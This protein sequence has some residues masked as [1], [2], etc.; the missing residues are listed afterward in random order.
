MIANRVTRRLFLGALALI[1][2]VPAIAQTVTRGPYLQKS[3]TDRIIFRWRTSV[4]TNSRVQYGATPATLTSIADDAA[5]TTEHRVEVL[6]LSANTTYYYSVG[7]TTQV[8]AGGDANHFFIT[9]PTSAKPTRIWVIGDAGTGATAQT[10]VRDAY[11]TFTGTRHTDLW[12]MLGDNAYQSGT[13]AEY[14]TGVFNVYQSLLRKSVVWPTFGNHDAVSADSATLTGPYYDIFSLPR[15]AEAGGIASGTEAYYSFDYGNIHFI[16]L[17]S[18]ESSRSTTGPMAVWLQSDLAST[19]K[20][21]IIAFWHHPPYSKGSHDSDTDSIMIEMRTNF[22]PILEAGGVDLVLTGHSHSYERSYL[23]DGHYGLSTT[24]TA[25]MKKDAGSGR[26][27]GAGAYKKPSPGIAPHEGAVYAVAGSSGQTAGGAL[28]HPAMFISLNLLGSM[29]LDVN[30]NRLDAKFID[31]TGAT[32]DYFTLIKGSAPAPP[33]SLT[34]TAASTSQINLAWTD[35]SSNEEGF[36]VERSTDNVTF[37]QI[38]QTAANST[39]YQD[40]GL[41][42][43]TLYYYRVRAANNT[44]G[45]SAYSNVASATTQSATPQPPTGLSAVAASTSQINLAWTDNSSNEENFRVE[46]ST[47][48]ISFAEIAVTVA[49]AAAYQ[50]AGL[51]AATKYYYRAR[52]FNTAGGFSGYSNIAN[53]T[54]L[55]PPPNAPSSLTATAIS[56][57]QINLAWNDGSSNEDGFKVE[58]STDNLN[59]AQIATVGA[60]VTGYQ[61]TALNS[62]T[63][64]Y[65]RV[66]AYNTGGNSGYTNTTSATTQGVTAPAAPTGLTAAAVTKSQINL[67]WTDASSNE[68]GFKIERSTDGISFLQITTVGAGVTSYANTGLTKNK[69]YYYRVRAYNAGGDSPYSNIANARTPAR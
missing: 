26:E 54:T 53:A 24:L 39:G 60:G 4:A 7:S 45:D 36:K 65:F 13:D 62:G 2:A 28:N 66:R 11:Y 63:I 23:L 44:Y 37:A 41:N 33:A 20:Q 68:T 6:G 16:C 46:R 8:L 55:T 17:D 5:S 43:N 52:A 59:F 38:T 18:M 57:S 31:N 1:L 12:L 9:P 51:P 42:S 61:S 14:T 30:G 21:W 49:N 58:R 15:T 19:N 47:D 40:N 69:R 29:V 25:S 35:N 32:K 56:T 10:Q 48:G 22:L 34:A 3:G 67:N 50:D 27:D 64:Y